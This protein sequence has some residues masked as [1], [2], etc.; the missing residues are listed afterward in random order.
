MRIKLSHLPNHPAFRVPHA[1]EASREV[2]RVGFKKGQV[3]ILFG[4]RD[5]V[6]LEH[7]SLSQGGVVEANAAVVLLVF[8]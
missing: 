4:Y 2:D 6:G 5:R 8:Q 3:S 1:I 7:P